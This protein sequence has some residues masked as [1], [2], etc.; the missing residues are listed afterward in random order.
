MFCFRSSSLG[1]LK[2]FQ[3]WP[4]YLEQRRPSIIM[5]WSCSP[6]CLLEAPALRTSRDG[7]DGW[8]GLRFKFLAASSEASKAR[9]FYSHAW[10]KSFA[11]WK[12]ALAVAMWR[13]CRERRRWTRRMEERIS[14][15][16]CLFWL[17]YFLFF[18]FSRCPL[19]F[20]SFL[21]FSL[22]SPQDERKESNWN[23][24]SPQLRTNGQLKSIKLQGLLAAKLYDCRPLWIFGTLLSGAA[25]AEAASPCSPAGAKRISLGKD[26]WNGR[27][28]LRWWVCSL[29]LVFI[30]HFPFRLSALEHVFLVFVLFTYYFLAE[31]FF[32]LQVVGVVC[33]FIYFFSYFNLKIDTN[34]NL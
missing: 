20:K 2:S 5:L 1:N 27:G 18:Y 23:I 22:Q 29:A 7:D 4:I 30:L 8:R 14:A 12:F 16:F 33:L 26:G 32:V 31:V 3:S 24:L 17:F 34:N 11:S 13:L 25:E 28:M 10:N 15:L 19:L 9:S 21:L 6:A